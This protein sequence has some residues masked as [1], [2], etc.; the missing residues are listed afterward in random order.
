MSEQNWTPG[1][2]A[3]EIDSLQQL[4][5]ELVIEAI[6]RCSP[7]APRELD[8]HLAK[9]REEYAEFDKHELTELAIAIGMWDA[10]RLALAIQLARALTPDLEARNDFSNERIV[11]ALV[12]N[13]QQIA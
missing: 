13:A 1:Y 9:M 2:L 3:S 7:S 5:E 4:H 12:A 8:T 6:E 10:E 11:Q